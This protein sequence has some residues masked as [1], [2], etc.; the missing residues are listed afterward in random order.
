[1]KSFRTL[2]VL[3]AASL[4]C[5]VL[6]GGPSANATCIGGWTHGVLDPVPGITSMQGYY[7]VAMIGAN[8]GWI[9][10]AGEDY[11]GSVP[12]LQR[13]TPSGWA[14]FDAPVLG[15][16]TRYFG[17]DGLASN[18]VWVVGD[19]YQYPNSNYALAMHWDGATWTSQFALG[20]GSPTFR[21]VVMTASDDV[22]ASGRNFE[23]VQQ[24]QERALIGHWDGASWTKAELPV[25]ASGS[26]PSLWGI[27][28]T[29]PNDVWSVGRAW[30]GSGNKTYVVHWNGAQWSEVPSPNTGSDYN[31]FQDVVAIAP[32]DAW[33]VGQSSSSSGG[34]EKTLIAHWDGSTWSQVPSPNPGNRGNSLMAIASSG[35]RL[36]AVGYTRSKSKRGGSLILERKGG[37]WRVITPP[38]RGEYETLTAI[39]GMASGAGFVAAGYSSQGDIV[40]S[41]C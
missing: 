2:K 26:Q 25:P 35:D 39:D 11:K 41:T 27:D 31:S 28:A 29:G 13:L 7:G 5:T 18:D 20:G 34:Y 16:S 40:K 10:G 6:V 15:D 24:D 9:A 12:A 21:D 8:D 33:A 23:G 38:P 1:M 36:F 3:A 37:E 19:A 14:P 17:A 32:N 22:W 4:V 30:T